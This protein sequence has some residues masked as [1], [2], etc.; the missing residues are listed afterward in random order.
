MSRDYDRASGREP[1]GQRS[2]SVLDF[3]YHDAQRIGSFLAQFDDAGY[4][5]QVT[6]GESAGTKEQGVVSVRGRAGLPG[7][8][9]G[10][11]TEIDKAGEEGFETS[12]RV[13]D[14]LWANAR[15]LLDY[16]ESRNLIHRDLESAR[17]GQFVLVTGKIKIIDSGMFVNL[18]DD[19]K[20]QALMAANAGEAA[21][22]P[23]QP[24]SGARGGSRGRSM[25]SGMDIALMLL[26]MMPHSI[27]M[28]IIGENKAWCNLLKGGL[29]CSTGDLLLMHGEQLEGT[30]HV[31]G[32]LN[33]LNDESSLSLPDE[34][35]LA[36]QEQAGMV[37]EALR[38]ITPVGRMFLGRPADAYG[39]TPL[40]V[41]RE[42][43][44]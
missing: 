35:D 44:T 1:E 38:A 33:A 28:T 31:L 11:L 22:R 16:L 23:L 15:T 37:T 40:I 18:W 41:F 34:D 29:V 26:K 4:L 19:K 24:T 2:D 43:V 14:P 17:I 3:L 21:T 30:W 9:G 5:T 42:I 6:Q 36:E 27:Q 32:I 10:Q 8:L 12:Q 20:F 13:Y 39:L 7:L 25:P